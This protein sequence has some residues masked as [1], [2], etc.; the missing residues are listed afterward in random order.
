MVYTR[1]EQSE[2]NQISSMCKGEA[3]KPSSI[4]KE[5]LDGD[6]IWGRENHSFEAQNSYAIV[7]SSIPMHKLV[8]ITKLSRTL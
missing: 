6:N 8:V 5:P 3:Y 2:D 7:D 4:T 1:P